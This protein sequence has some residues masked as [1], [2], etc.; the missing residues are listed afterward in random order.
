MTVCR[1]TRIL[2]LL[3]G[4]VE[5][6]HVDVE[7]HDRAPMLN[8][9]VSLVVTSCGHQQRVRMPFSST[10]REMNSILGQLIPGPF[11]QSAASL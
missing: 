8:L 7:D 11:D 10:R 1:Q 6:V 5:G 3:N 9:A 4:G 2:S